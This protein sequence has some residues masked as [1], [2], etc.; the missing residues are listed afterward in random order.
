MRGQMMNREMEFINESTLSAEQ[1][2]QL[3]QIKESQQAKMQELMQ[4][5]R[6]G[7]G[8]SET[9]IDT[10]WKAHM[11]EIRPFVAQDQL[12]EFDAFVAEGKPQMPRM[13]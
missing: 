3:D 10:I 4:S 1:K 6:T 13:M 2:T 5:F 8:V 9:E 11:A 12:D 7:S